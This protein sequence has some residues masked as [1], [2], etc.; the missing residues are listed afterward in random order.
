MYGK[1]NMEAY[2]T[3]CKIDSQREFAVWLGKLK[4][5]LCVNLEGWG[6]EGDGREVQ[7]GGDTCIPMADPC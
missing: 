6:G 2:I 7:K 1:S 4:R 5:G 3:M